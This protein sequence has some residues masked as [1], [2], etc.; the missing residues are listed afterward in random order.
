MKP[1]L[2][3]QIPHPHWHH[4]RLIRGYSPQSAP[5]EMIEVSVGNEDQINRRQM[6][7]FEAR[8]LQ[9]FDHL[10]P[11]RP[12]RIDQYVDVVGLNEKRGVSDPGDANFAFLD[13]RK[14]RRRITA[15]AF[16]E[17]RRNKNAGEKIAFVP[18][19]SRT[20]ADAGRP[21]GRGAIARYLANDIAS[22]SFFETNRHFRGSI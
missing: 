6:M 9:S 15:G 3:H 1:E 18:V 13:F 5:I 21:F 20:K 2:V 16:D 4:D 7:D 8:P 10:E 14:L 12:D 17:E 19:G 11:L 22:A